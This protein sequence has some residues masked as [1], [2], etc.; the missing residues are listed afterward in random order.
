M[1]HHAPA[2]EAELD[3]FGLAF[4]AEQQEALAVARPG[5]LAVGEDLDAREHGRILRGPLS[6][7]SAPV[8]LGVLEL[9]ALAPARFER[10]LDRR[11]GPR[12]GSRAGLIAV[13]AQDP[14][15]EPA[16]RTHLL[17]EL[18]SIELAD[19]SALTR[20]V[21]GPGPAEAAEDEEAGDRLVR[22]SLAR[23]SG[24]AP[25]APRAWNSTVAG[26]DTLRCA[27]S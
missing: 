2:G 25:A 4:G 9:E 19:E 22:A 23:K 15:I 1:S 26:G 21:E 6:Q 14:G 20:H 17:Q 12:E 5:R 7:R 13:R 27:G 16:A 24:P 10:D 3:R 18:L 8:A 11:A